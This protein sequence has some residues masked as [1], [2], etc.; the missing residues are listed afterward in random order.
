MTTAETPEPIRVA[1]LLDARHFGGA[2]EIARRLVRAAPASGVDARAYILS[3]GHLAQVL[4]EEGLP[5][6][7]FS[8]AGKFD[9]R[10]LGALA[11]A[12]REDRV[13]II[14]AHTSRTHL[15]ARI[16]ARRLRIKN[17]TT[18]HSPIALD[19][20]RGA[21]RHPLRALIERAGRPWTDLIVTVS[22]E[23]RDRLI[24]EERVP[25]RRVVWIPN[26]AEPVQP[27]REAARARLEAELARHGIQTRGMRLAMI[28][29]MRPRKGP[30]VLLR[31]FARHLPQDPEASL[32]MIGDDSFT[33]GAGYLDT[34]KQLAAELGI[35]GHT[36][37]TGFMRDPWSLAAG[38]DALVLPS[39]FGEGMPLVLLEAMNHGL[40]FFASN[41]AGNRELVGMGSEGG[42]DGWPCGWVHD[43]GN[44]GHLAAELYEAFL[45]RTQLTERGRRGRDAF[46]RNFT[47]GRVARLYRDQYAR[48]LEIG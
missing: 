1:H 8:S 14:Q 21:V 32:L 10:M 19:E 27:D 40:P 23:E 2:E 45:N 38:A 35:A 42:V 9:L 33:D 6:R 25:E 7:V 30:E 15:I 28:A 24:R 37:F 5:V 47:I 16:V 41:S 29:Q 34:L 22:S 39:L 48:M 17:I 11:R 26:G 31:A 46:L 36:L 43:P 13:Q 18:I 12:A 4:R 44:A 3:E 20:N